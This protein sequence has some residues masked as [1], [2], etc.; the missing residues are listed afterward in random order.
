M[1]ACVGYTRRH[2]FGVP[3]RWSYVFIPLCFYRVRHRTI[4]GFFLL[5][6]GTLVVG[7]LFY[8][9]TPHVTYGGRYWFSALPFL[10]LL[11][12]V[13]LDEFT[14]FCA[15]HG[16]RRARGFMYMIVA[17]LIGWNLISYSPK[18][19]REAEQVGHV[20]VA[21]KGTAQKPTLTRVVV[22]GATR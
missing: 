18:R 19:F 16:A 8:W 2:L 15:A 9:A 10:V 17:L 1:C 22:V 20:T 4:H 11:S 12:A 13:G 14:T 7:H 3:L 6:F 21:L 5:V